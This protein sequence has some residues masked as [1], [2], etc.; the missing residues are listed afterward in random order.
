[1]KVWVGGSS[2]NFK[3]TTSSGSLSISESKDH[4]F[5]FFGKKNPTG[6]CSFRNLKELTV[7]MKEF[8]DYLPKLILLT[9]LITHDGVHTQFDN[10][11]VSVPHSKN[12]PTVLAGNYTM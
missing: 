6:S 2:L 5:P 7:F 11:Q 10:Q 8:H 9:I 1:M 4:W 3:E 12:H